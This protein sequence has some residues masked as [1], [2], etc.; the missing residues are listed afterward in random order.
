MTCSPFERI[1]G[2]PVSPEQEAAVESV[3]L[4][5]IV[6]H[7]NRG[8]AIERLRIIAMAREK[9]DAARLRARSGPV[10]SLDILEAVA[11]EFERFAAKLERDT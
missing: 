2:E 4:A 9:A 10:S 1:D 6:T 7:E 5:S 3:A 11:E 8:A